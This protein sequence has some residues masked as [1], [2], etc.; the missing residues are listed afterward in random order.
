MKKIYTSLILILTMGAFSSYGQG[1]VTTVP[2]LNGG[3]GSG[4]TTFNLNTNVPIIIDSFYQAF[5]SV[6]GQSVQ[7]W[8]N[9]TAI[10]GAPTINAA[11]G[12][13]Q[14]GTSVSVN[15]ISVGLTPTLQ[16]IPQNYG[17]MMPAGATWGFYIGNSVNTSVIY[18]TFGSGATSFTD[19]TVTITNGPSVG[20]GGAIPNPTFSTRQWNGSVIYSL[21]IVDQYPYCQ[22][23]EGGD[24]GWASGGTNNEWELGTPSNTIIN[25]ASSGTEAWGVDLDGD[26]PTNMQASVT[27][28]NFDMTSLN[29]PHISMDVWWESEF[30]WDGAN[31]EYS[32][33]GGS[34]W[35]TVGSTTSAGTNWYTN[36]DVD[37][38]SWSSSDEG[39]TGRNGT[40]S[41]GGSNGWVT[42]E[43]PL[44]GLAGQGDVFMRVNFGSDG[45]VVD[46][47][48]AFDDVIVAELNDVS[49][50]EIL[51]DDSIC[52]SPSDTIWGV[53]T[54]NGINDQ[55]GF[56]IGIDTNGTSSTFTYTGTLSI[57]DLDTIPLL[58]FNSENGGLYNVSAWTNLSGDDN[59]NNDTAYADSIVRF[60][61][62]TGFVHGG[63]SICADSI[64]DITI[65][66]TGN[67]P[68]VLGYSDSSTNTFVSGITTSPYTVTTNVGGVYSLVSILDVNGCQ[69]TSLTGNATLIVNALPVIDLG[70]DSTFCGT[71][72]LDPGAG[73]TSYLWQDGTT[74][75]QTF[76]ANANDN[77]AVTVTDGNG[78]TGSDD[79]DLNANPLPVV[80]LGADIELCEGTS[81][82]LNAGPGFLGYVWSDST[83]G[84]ILSVNTLGT[85]SVSV[86]DFNGCQGTDAIDVT[87]I[88][89]LP[90]PSLGPNL[91]VAPGTSVILDPGAF[92]S[93]LWQD[94][95][96]TSQQFNVAFN[97]T[98]YVEVT[99]SNGCMASD[100][101]EVIFWP[102]GIGTIGSESSVNLYPNPTSGV[103]N[104][105]LTGVKGQNIELNVLNVQ[106][107]VLKQERLSNL[108]DEH[109]EQLDLS[110]MAKGLYFVELKNDEGSVVQ[111]V[112]VK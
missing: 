2:P 31:L 3:N 8:Y 93:Y 20:Y 102:S 21:A 44:T 81:S 50:V 34:S 105:E 19:G 16:P 108:A 42:S 38:L 45:S 90:V 79:V 75:T 95:T 46:E 32:I 40:G 24:G 78:C 83:T 37:G 28:P 65:D 97:G 62:P 85:Y 12:W 87:A 99:D 109:N 9:T 86:T 107:K 91:S 103:L 72:L 67:G 51:A 106:G 82:T 59:I 98:Y 74:T 17:L 73:F 49:I 110:G 66:I 71:Q 63:G 112:T 1:T 7:V 11:N 5:Q 104:I 61:L 14:V 100:T 92:S 23:F 58:T 55:T 27:S 80:N 96:T 30:S 15:G 60:S 69:A 4:G 33:D 70:P 25:S 41:T 89:P 68:W 101:A 22:D 48:F 52:G 88:N 26:Y 77:Y 57:K 76:L 6:A 94:G 13:V 53:V 47:G 56:S 64:F 35:T 18:T 111:R 43:H 36:N 54:N 84:Q 10:N 39:W 29:N